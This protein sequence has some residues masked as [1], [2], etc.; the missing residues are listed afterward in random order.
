MRANASITTTSTKTNSKRDMVAPFTE[1]L[2]YHERKSVRENG[3]LRIQ[4]REARTL[5]QSLENELYCVTITGSD[6]K[7]EFQ[8]IKDLQKG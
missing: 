1:I 7:Y 2:R 3:F 5:I 6:P 4:L 8:K